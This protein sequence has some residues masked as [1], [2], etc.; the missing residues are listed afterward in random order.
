MSRSSVDLLAGAA[1]AP[2]S[3]DPG[4]AAQRQ[5]DRPQCPVQAAG[6]SSVA[7]G[8]ARDLLGERRLG[9]VSV[10]AQEPADLQVD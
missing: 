8:Q 5:R 10:P 2:L 4:A 3:R 6:A 9:A 1:S 7:G